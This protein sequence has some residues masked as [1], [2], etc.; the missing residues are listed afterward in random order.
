MTDLQVRPA[1]R[2]DLDGLV[3]TDADAHQPGVVLVAGD[4]PVG[5]ARAAVLEGHAHLE[6][7]R[8]EGTDADSVRAAL[9]EGLS[10][11]LSVR[12]F[13]TLTA[14]GGA[15]APV[16]EKLL[17]ELGFVDVP[18]DEPPTKW[19]A[20]RAPLLRRTLLRHRTTAELEAFLPALDEASHADEGTLRLLVRRP[21]RGEREIL[22]V[23]ELDVE[24]GLLGDTWRERGSNRTADG[25]AHPDMQLNLMS[26]PLIEFLAQ[27]PDREALA[28]D[29]MYVD[30][31]LSHDNL[32]VGSR[33]LIGDPAAGP[34][35]GAVI[36]VT[37]QPHTG[38]ARFIARFGKDA[39]T[40]VN[41]P[42]GKPR[43]LRGL[44]AKVV[45][46]GLVRAGD[47]VRVERPGA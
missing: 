46:A 36:E 27:D 30:L 38:C 29:Q 9:L 20:G 4:P 44:C 6:R 39:M 35:H 37:E 45:T 47:R 41:G 12:G 19:L 31:D 18:D 16:D 34:E 24:E 14:V 15:Q 11:R 10:E 33:L 28:G 1:R 26:H 7:V 13:G 21:A 25:S 23:G 5:F 3:P 40:F 22:E 2:R 17:R 8:A 43:R 42:E 32:P